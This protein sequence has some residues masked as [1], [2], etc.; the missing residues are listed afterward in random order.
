MAVSFITTIGTT[1]YGFDW[2]NKV[3][4]IEA[5][6]LEITAADL[7]EAIHDA[8]DGVEGITFDQIANFGNP[9]VLT[10]SSSTFLNVILLSTWKILTLSTSSTF[11][12]GSGNVVHLTDGIAIFAPNVLVTLVNNTSA[13]GVL[14]ETGVSGLTPTESAALISGEAKTV[15]LWKLLGLDDTDEVSITPAGITTQLGTFVINFTGDGVT[16]TKMTRVP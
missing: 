7:K 2:V 4:E 11:T 15:D 3:I 1:D 5:A 16:L 10:A 13:A 8:Q 9:V 12:V 14:V 6:V